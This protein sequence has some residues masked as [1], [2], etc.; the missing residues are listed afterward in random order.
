MA[1]DHRM[2]IRMSGRMQVLDNDLVPAPV[3]SVLEPLPALVLDH[4]ALVVELLLGERITERGQTVGL[5][6]Q[7]LLEVR[8]RHG[9]EIVGAIGVGG[10]VDAAFAQVGAGVLDDPEV[11][12]G[13][14]LR[15]LEHQMLEEMREAGPP[16]LFVL[17]S[18]VVPLVHVDDRQLAIDVQ[19]HLQT[20]GKRVLLERDLGHLLASLARRGHGPHLARQGDSGKCGDGHRQGS[21]KSAGNEFSG[22]Q[23]VPPDLAGGTGSAPGPAPASAMGSRSD[24]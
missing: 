22:V 14:V 15:A 19:D 9:G 6:P 20:V 4:V 5:D 1:A 16:L 18:N 8:G 24:S 21:A 13:N 3:G 10:A 17:G 11:L 12:A 2:R 23:R 7:E